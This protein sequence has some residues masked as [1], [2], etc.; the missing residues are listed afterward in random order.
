MAHYVESP[1]PSNERTCCTCLHTCGPVWVCSMGRP[2]QIRPL[3][4]VFGHVGVHVRARFCTFLG[5]G[6][7]F[8]PCPSKFECKVTRIGQIRL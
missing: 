7:T 6:S 4:A 1:I 2:E 8:E 5:P 3:P